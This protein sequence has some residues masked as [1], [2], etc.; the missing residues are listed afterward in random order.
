MIWI[1]LIMLAFNCWIFAKL[2]AADFERKNFD[3]DLGW[4]ALIISALNLTAF[5]FVAIMSIA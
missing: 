5:F 2:S 4:D 1:A 3:E